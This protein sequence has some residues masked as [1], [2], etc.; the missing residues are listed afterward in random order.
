[1]MI[2]EETGAAPEF[3]E[4]AQQLPEADDVKRSLRTA[5]TELHDGIAQD[6]FSTSIEV[7]ELLGVVG[8]PDAARERL[9]RIASNLHQTSLELRGVLLSM[10]EAPSEQDERTV[11]ERVRA[12]VE[13]VTQ[14]SDLTVD[15]KLEGTGSEPAESCGDLLVRC[16]REGLTNIIKHTEATEVLVIIR[17]SDSWWTVMIED[18]GV[19]EPSAVRHLITNSACANLGLASLSSEAKRLRGRLWLSSAGTLSGINL[20]LSVPAQA[21]D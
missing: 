6:L 11:V 17:R 5:A 4:T 10:F 8:L 21:G 2:L 9:E 15:I 20:S 13:K 7:E 18:D 16:V 12:N 14:R 1:M 3:T 19:G